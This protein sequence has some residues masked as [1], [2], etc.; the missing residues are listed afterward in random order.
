MKWQSNHQN[1]RQQK[2]WK[3]IKK[4][5]QFWRKIK[6]KL[7]RKNRR[8]L[9]P[10][11]L[12]VLEIDHKDRLERKT[13]NYRKE[14]GREIARQLTTER[15]LCFDF[16]AEREQLE[17]ESKYMNWHKNRKNN[18]PNIWKKITKLT[19]TQNHWDFFPLILFHIIIL[20]QV[21]C[22]IDF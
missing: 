10:L 5:L 16:N 3:K 6:W 13:G 4:N 8:R 20:L 7:T 9:K 1:Q 12:R 11:N 21:D 17:R 22:N 18:C 14:S 19:I 2:E 15:N